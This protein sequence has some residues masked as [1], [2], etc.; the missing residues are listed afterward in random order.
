MM[1]D[2]KDSMLMN[3]LDVSII[4][5]FILFLNRLCNQFKIRSIGFACPTQICNSMLKRNATNVISYFIHVMEQNRDKQFIL[6]PYH[7]QS[8]WLLLVICMRSKSIC[9]LYPLPSDRDIGEIKVSINL[10]FRSIPTNGRIKNIDWKPCKFVVMARANYFGGEFVSSII[11]DCGVFAMRHMETYVGQSI[12]SWDCGLPRGDAR[13][14]LALCV[15]Y[16][17]EILMFQSNTCLQAI[18]SSVGGGR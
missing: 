5:V 8:H 1:K 4:Q 16:V 15:Q 13:V 7:Q 3:W 2:I 17:F 18:V 14:L 12:A 9:F 10:A 11:L 6:A